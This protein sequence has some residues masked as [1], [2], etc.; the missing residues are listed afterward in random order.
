MEERAAH[1]AP[2]HPVVRCVRRLGGTALTVA[3]LASP[4]AFAAPAH[5]D[6][7]S[8]W[9]L[10]QFKAAQVW[11]I[12]KG[13]GS[14]VA[15]LDTGVS[16]VPD[17]QPNLLAGADFGSSTSS[18]GTGQTDLEGHGTAMAAIIAGTGAAVTEGIGCNRVRLPQ[19]GPALHAEPSHRSPDLAPAGC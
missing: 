13:S 10:Q 4:L 12:T 7:S 15:V 14:T 8:Q 17:T 2:G 16:S 18:T 5:A 19:P 3:L 9:P 11:N 1:R 6:V